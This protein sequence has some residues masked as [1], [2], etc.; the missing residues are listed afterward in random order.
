M[1]DKNLTLVAWWVVIRAEFATAAI[2]YSFHHPIAATLFLIS[3]AFDLYM[4]RES[5]RD[6]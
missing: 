4:I 6:A 5:E 3:G 1:T 2:L